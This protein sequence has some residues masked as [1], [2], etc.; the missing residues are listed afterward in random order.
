MRRLKYHFIIS[1]VKIK[2]VQVYGC[3]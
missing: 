3:N 1:V 2:A